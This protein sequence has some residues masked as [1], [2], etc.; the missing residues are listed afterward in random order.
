[1]LQLIVGVARHGSLTEDDKRWCL[2]EPYLPVRDTEA[3]T[4][5]WDGVI[6]P[7]EVQ[8]PGSLLANSIRWGW[9]QQ[10]QSQRLPLCLG[11]GRQGFQL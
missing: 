8:A 2:S 9:A 10:A 5:P 7:G 1:M 11:S 4:K 6:V 3:D